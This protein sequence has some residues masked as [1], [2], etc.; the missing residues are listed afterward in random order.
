MKNAI[1]LFLFAIIF[2]IASY[3]QNDPCCNSIIVS[4]PSN[5]CPNTEVSYYSTPSCLYST[6]Y[7]WQIS[8]GEYTINSW[9][10]EQLDIVF[11][12]ENTSYTVSQKRYGLGCLDSYSNYKSVTTENLPSAPNTPSGEQYPSYGTEYT[13]TTNSVSGAC[14]GGSAKPRA[15][16]AS[17]S[18]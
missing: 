1:I 8:G 3:S 18:T 13:Y 5:P 4:G 11:E 15:P 9:E 7:Q 10:S 16:R 2:S 17:G 12:D 6:Q 14:D